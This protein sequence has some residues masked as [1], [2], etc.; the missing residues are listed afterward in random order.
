MQWGNIW[1]P[2]RIPFYLVHV[3]A[4]DFMINELVIQTARNGRLSNN[5]LLEM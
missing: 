1:V 4:K 2:N 5:G 3:G